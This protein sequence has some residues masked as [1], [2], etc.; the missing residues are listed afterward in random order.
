M[1]TVKIIYRDVVQKVAVCSRLL[2]SVEQRNVI[3]RLG[4]NPVNLT[5]RS[6][7]SWLTVKGTREV[8]ANLGCMGC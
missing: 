1:A 7:W 2:M 4:A 6:C 8:P 5:D 3:C